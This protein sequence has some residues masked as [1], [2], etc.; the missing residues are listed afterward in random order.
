MPHRIGVLAPLANRNFRLLAIG[1]LTSLM[2]DGFFRVALAVQ[3][4]AIVG[5]RPGAIAVVGIAWGLGQTF[6]LPFGGWAG[7]RF[8]RRRVL[9]AADAWRGTMIGGIGLLSVTG[10]L[11]L[12]HMVVLGFGFGVGN[13]FFN[14]TATAFVPDL[15]PSGKLTQANSFLGVARP[16]M[17]YIVGPVI[18]AGLVWLGGPGL[19]FLMDAA[20]FGVSI[21]LVSRI[22]VEQPVRETTA[23]TP[24]RDI[25]EG[26]Q[27][28][29]RTR[30][31]WLWL[32]GAGLGTLMFHGPFDVLLPVLL[33]S[34]FDMTG[35]QVALT[36]AF[37]LAAGGLGAMV[38]GTAIAQWDL[39]RRFIT[40]L[41]CAEAVATAALVLIGIMQAP[42]Q[43]VVAGGVLFSL[44]AVADIIWATTMQRFVPRHLLGRVASLDWFTGMSL[45]PISMAVA[46]GLDGLMGPRGALVVAGVVGTTA[47]VGLLMV[48]GA[49]D[50]ERGRVA[51]AGAS[52]VE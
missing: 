33:A 46:W 41:Y 10:N 29:V 34:E 12:W 49:R 21:A 32:L 50:P 47:L 40:T 22:R 2:G 51:P 13:G 8:E 48:P 42:W 19:A 16:A 35:E 9:M 20:T 31:A 18:G 1:N 24:L 23:A 27:Y 36:L 37:V 26:L 7:D 45:A 30:W 52:G 38:A 17:V 3:V 6:A 44:F 25:L 14:P 5:E 28:V 43:A 15:V 39:P 11:E 4:I